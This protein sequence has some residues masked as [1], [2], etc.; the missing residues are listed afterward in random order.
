[1]S[2]GIEIGLSLLKGNSRSQPGNAVD[3]A[4]TAA[5]MR[6]LFRGVQTQRNKHLIF[7]I[8]IGEALRQN[9]NDR[10]I[11]IIH[12][13]AFADDL[14]IA[15][16]SPLPQTVANDRSG[17]RLGLIIRAHKIA[18]QQRLHS[19]GAKKLGSDVPTS[20]MLRRAFAGEDESLALNRRHAVEDVIL[21]VIV[22]KLG[23]G[24]RHS[25]APFECFR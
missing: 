24:K 10:V 20:Q 12:S 16:K 14:R 1:R 2:D 7:L 9:S 23:I 13:D 18:T 25:W 11:A 22:L 19:Q 5:K 4:V 8:S 6:I 17:R 3:A 21:M 15:A